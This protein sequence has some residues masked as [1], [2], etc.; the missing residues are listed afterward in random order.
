VSA[1]EAGFAQERTCFDQ[2]MAQVATA[3][4]RLQRIATSQARTTIR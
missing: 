2:Q 1:V 4:L 3:R